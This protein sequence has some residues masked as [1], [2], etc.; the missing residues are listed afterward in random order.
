M[1]SETIKLVKGG[2]KNL[3]KR[4]VD[5]DKNVKNTNNSVNASIGFSYDGNNWE[6]YSDPIKIEKNRKIYI[7]AVRYGWKESETKIVKL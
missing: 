1:L 6:V 2:L 7:K 3:S 5:T 4:T